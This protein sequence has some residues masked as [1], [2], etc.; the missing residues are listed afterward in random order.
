MYF[1]AEDRAG[2]YDI[3]RTTGI[4]VDNQKPVGETKAPE[5]DILPE[6]ANDNNLYKS[7][8]KIDLQVL[9][10]KY[11]GE[12]PSENG[13]YAGLNKVTY[14]IYT[15]DTEA[16]EQGVL[17]DVQNNL[18]KD[19]V[20][21]E[22]GL[23][24]SWSGN[25]VVSSGKFNSNNVFVEVTAV[26]NAGN[27][28]VTTTKAGQIQIDITA[29][30]IDVRY[31]NNTADSSRYFKQDRT[32]TIV[33]TER[34]FNP[35]DVKITLT[36]TDGS[37]PA[38]A[39]WTKTGAGGNQDGTTWTATL[40]YTADGDYTFDI[41]YTDMAGNKCTPVSYGDSVAPTEF[42][43]DKTTPVV[44][45]EYDNNNARS[46]NY[47]NK[48][49]TATVTIVEHNLEPNGADRDRVKITMTA[50]NDGADVA[51]PAVGTWSTNGNVHTATI[52]FREDAHY[53]FDIAVMDKAGNEA[54]DYAQD[55]FYVD[56]TAPTLQITGVENGSANKGDVMPVISYSDVNY[57]PEQV[58]ITLHG[59]NRQEVQLKGAYTDIHNGR[60]FTFENFAKEKEIDDIYTLTAALVDKAGN[61]T[62]ETIHF[63]VNR[64]GSTYVLSESTKK[65]NG[66][67]VQKASDVVVTE[68]NANSLTNIKIT[69]FKN[70]ETLLLKE[71]V[72][73]KI[74]VK[75]GNG[76]WY[77]YVYTVFAHNFEEDGV[78]R[79]VFH[80]EDLAGNVAENTLDT[81][82]TEVMFG[83]DK[84]KPN[85]VV[86][87][88]ESGVTYALDRMT[89]EMSAKDN[90]LLKSITVYLDDY[91]K[92]YQTWNAD[93]IAAIIANNE[94][95]N[96]EILGS[97]NAHKLKIVCVDAAGNEYVEEITDFFVTTNLF[98]R[99]YNN[100]PLFFGSIIGIFAIIGCIIFVVYRKRKKE[101]SKVS[102]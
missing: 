44:T 52:T 99:Y 63:S 69:L 62:K 95:F 33:I 8:V 10:P 27:T 98:V 77:Q 86:A 30:S 90:L 58:S 35:E 18:T 53:T 50:V 65:M 46:G 88:L 94:S 39:G 17:L 92:A 32:A 22:D 6:P 3:I 87:N 100:K 43:I 67:Y 102:Q 73:Y 85:L 56:Q 54:E 16:E 89:V 68:I 72:D 42:T 51:N 34:N 13:Y 4:V 26:D 66:S 11:N 59:A 31:S 71:G 91:D 37:I 97:T 20:F 55:D 38:L 14:R 70:N 9:D 5:I 61:E 41:Q 47:Y 2:N 48:T 101:E 1:R 84:T 40:S 60:T 80:S 76:Q 82:D 79:L 24:Y 93:E 29:P 96:F 7:D 23:I 12:T 49:R 15:K 74:D 19:A 83:V 28:R 64:F 81:K 78:Y 36:N 57:D 75:G 21:D 25:I 45:V